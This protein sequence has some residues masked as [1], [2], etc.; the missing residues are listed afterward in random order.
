[1]PTTNATEKLRRSVN[2]A[3]DAWACDLGDGRLVVTAYGPGVWGLLHAGAGVIT[4][5]N[6]FVNWRTRTRKLP[7]GVQRADVTLESARDGCVLTLEGDESVV[8]ALVEILRT[9]PPGPR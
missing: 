9:F 6:A 8:E 5:Y 7:R 3:D 4:G 2:A 1:L